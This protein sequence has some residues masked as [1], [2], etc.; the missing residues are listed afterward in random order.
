MG[1]NIGRRKRPIARRFAVT[2]N[3]KI[4]TLIL[5]NSTPVVGV[6]WPK[7]NVQVMYGT[8]YTRIII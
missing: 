2:G 1:G 4:D 8:I 3:S 6:L 7:L 5:F